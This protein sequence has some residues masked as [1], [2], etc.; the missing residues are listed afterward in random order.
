MTMP[1]RTNR[2]IPL[3]LLAAFLLACPNAAWADG[4]VL[5]Q[6]RFDAPIMET[7]PEFVS[8]LGQESPWV[9]RTIV[10]RIDKASEDEN[11]PALILTV[12][13]AMMG[14][15]Q[16]EEICQALKRFRDS[17]KNIHC[18]IETAGMG[19]YTLASAATDISI[20]PT[21]TLFLM[22]MS[23][24]ALYFRNTLDKLGVQADVIH[25]GDYKSAGEMFT[26][27][28]PSEAAE[29][30]LNWLFDG[31][32]ER[33]V[34][35]MADGR[36]LSQNQMTDAIDMGFIN[37]PKAVELKLVD[38]MEYR[39]EF[40]ER[41]KKLYGTEEEVKID[42]RYGMREMPEIDFSN[43]LA[44]FQFFGELLKAGKEPKKPT[45][46]VI[47]L[48]GMIVEGKST[49][50]P[51][52]G[53]IAGSRTVA[54]AF[55]Q[56]RKDDKVKAVVFRVDSPGGSGSASDIILHAS[57]RLAD[58]KPLIVSMGNVAGSGGYWVSMGAHT[59]Y[60][61]PSTITASIGVVSAKFVLSGLWDKLGFTTYEY[62]RGK[63]ADMF[64]TNRPFTQE[65]RELLTT[66]MQ[67]FYKEF[68][69]RVMANRGDK[70][71]EDLENLAGGRV[72][73][74]AQALDNGLVDKLGGLDD[75]VKEAARQAHVSTY[76]IITL[77]APKSI[78]DLIMED[79]GLGGDEEDVSAAETATQLL[80]QWPF[81]QRST[82]SALQKLAPE[83]A[84]A[85]GR[86]LLRLYLMQSEGVIAAMPF[87]LV[88]N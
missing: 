65:Q 12:D 57:K 45:I 46:A 86:M 7:P 10:E 72:Y 83:Q 58:E 32:Y 70:L 23:A 31:L 62:N 24:E 51:L 1:R 55:E 11:V 38:R 64:N 56:A 35:Q 68:K 28:G 74:G 49:E 60:A 67:D 30:N 43:P 47:T 82:L 5:P 9:L 4:K 53:K 66:Y 81:E 41:V 79:L 6:F 39:P 29:K 61:D 71:H 76:E 75:A 33:R 25:I 16:M 22:G 88:I 73:T 2:W 21:G 34:G 54:A 8:L 63:F 78:F 59:I 13:A 37:A 3:G 84:K 52:L 15:A 14:R 48:E 26:R 18:Y 27:T 20:M 17:G 85:A 42:N 36:G 69:D 19:E 87:E 80:G 50:S 40:I 44:I 77:P